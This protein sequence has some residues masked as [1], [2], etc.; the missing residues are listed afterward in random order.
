MI[1]LNVA[2]K[3]ICF[4]VPALASAA[5]ARLCLSA[6]AGSRQH[7]HSCH[8]PHA[9]GCELRGWRQERR[10]LSGRAAGAGESATSGQLTHRPSALH[11]FGLSLTLLDSDS[12]IAALLLR[13][14]PR[15]VGVA[16]GCG[17][18]PERARGWRGVDA[19][20]Q[21]R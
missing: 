20:R 15:L 17:P 7:T 16:G 12:I 10:Q 9:D 6:C 11:Q 19:G 14:L 21:L 5:V 2:F 18:L 1:C 4:V 8:Y 3:Q 13:L